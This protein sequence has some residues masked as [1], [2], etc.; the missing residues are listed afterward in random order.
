MT[1]AERMELPPHLEEK[2]K[3]KAI[4]V[5]PEILERIIEQIAAGRTMTAIC[6]D[7][8]MPGK[9]AVYAALKACSPSLA[10][11][12]ARARDDQIE[13]WADQ[14]IDISDDAAGDWIEREGRN[15]QIERAFNMESVH[16]SKLRVESR[17]RLI[18]KL[19]PEKYGDQQR[20]EVHSRVTMLNPSDEL[21]VAEVA[22]RWQ[23]LK[24]MEDRAVEKGLLPPRE[25][26]VIDVDPE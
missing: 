20:L 9:T 25:G 26:G 3:R 23:F 14:V 6:R 2:P 13:S 5:T 4:P 21:S 19:K 24:F 17:I 12:Y 8:N 15:G 18:S 16:R 7:E 1:E 11:D 10:A 22:R